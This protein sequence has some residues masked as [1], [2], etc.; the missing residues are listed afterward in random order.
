MQAHRTKHVSILA[1]SSLLISSIVADIFEF[2]GEEFQIE[3]PVR[4]WETQDHYITPNIDTSYFVNKGTGISDCYRI[5]LPANYDVVE[6]KH[7]RTGYEIPPDQIS[8]AKQAEAGNVVNDKKIDDDAVVP[9]ID[10]QN[11]ETGRHKFTYNDYQ[12]EAM[13]LFST[14]DCTGKYNLLE[15]STADPI[16]SSSINLKKLDVILPNNPDVIAA[17]DLPEIIDL[18]QG[19]KSF[20]L[21]D[22]NGISDFLMMEFHKQTDYKFHMYMMDGKVRI[23]HEESQARLAALAA[24]AAAELEDMEDFYRKVM[25]QANDDKKNFRGSNDGRHL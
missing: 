25:A 9:Y 15:L 10:V 22:V 8:K 19:Y 3:P 11:G 7:T 6:I 20:R 21:Y 1:I 12:V 18:S 16:V 17:N 4:A 2:T 14:E 13:T 24:Q 5:K 23:F